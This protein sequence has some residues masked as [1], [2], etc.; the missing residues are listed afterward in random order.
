V[1]LYRNHYRSLRD[2]SLGFEWFSSKREAERAAR[3]D[4]SL[5]EG[6]DD[7][8]VAEPM[9]FTPTREGILELLR[10]VADHPDNG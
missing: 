4:V 5:P 9:K 7:H 2:G 10:R 3:Q 6:D 1:K 8:E